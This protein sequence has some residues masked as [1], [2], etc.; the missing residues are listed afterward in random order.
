MN[1]IFLI[2]VKKDEILRLFL[3]HIIFSFG[4]LS[5]RKFSIFE[6]GVSS[7]IL[8]IFYCVFILAL[9]ASSLENNRSLKVLDPQSLQIQTKNCFILY[10]DFIFGQFIRRVA[11]TI[12]YFVI[13]HGHHSF[14]LSRFVHCQRIYFCDFNLQN[15]KLNFEVQDSIAQIFIQIFLYRTPIINLYFD[16]QAL[17]CQ[18]FFFCISS[19]YVIL[20]VKDFFVVFIMP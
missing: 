2:L 4:N 20:S 10:I 12:K 16:R 14:G 8:Q 17:E 5:S 1:L 6:L 19:I 13:F 3:L 7:R 9:I 11:Y 18:K 15:S